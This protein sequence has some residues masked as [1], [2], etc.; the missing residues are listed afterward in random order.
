MKRNFLLLAALLAGFVLTSSLFAQ[1]EP[2]VT[3]QVTDA[4]SSA[5]TAPVLLPAAEVSTDKEA[6]EHITQAQMNERGDSD[7]SEAM[8]WVPGV[9]LTGAGGTRNQT[10][11]TLR[12]RAEA[13]AP[14]YADGV[15]WM[16]PSRPDMDY[17]RFLTGDLESVDIMKGYTSMLLGP[18]NLAGAVVMRF[19][20]PKK[21]FEANLKTSW[22]FDAGGYAGN[23]QTFSAAQNRA[24]FTQ[25]Q[26]FSGGT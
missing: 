1:T 14:V 23:L 15:P 4:E 16:D 5:E 2:Q 7:L 18:N 8:R 24:C 6:T 17:S 25:K 12:G 9:V 19:A 21:A 3:T 20:K 26:A 11:F 10:G 22:D 13:D